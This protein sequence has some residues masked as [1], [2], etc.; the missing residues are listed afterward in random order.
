M[1]RFLNSGIYSILP[2][3]RQLYSLYILI[4]FAH[5]NKA[6]SNINSLIHNIILCI[7]TKQ[8]IAYSLF[9]HRKKLIN[10]LLIGFGIHEGEG[11]S[12]GQNIAQG[13]DRTVTNERR[14]R[15]EKRKQ[16][17]QQLDVLSIPVEGIPASFH[18]KERGREQ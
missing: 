8:S 9:N 12:F 1:I 7:A 11:V 15:V 5:K 6:Q 3:P 16:Q 4:V 13:K 2:I 10:Q 14:I 18:Y 17:V